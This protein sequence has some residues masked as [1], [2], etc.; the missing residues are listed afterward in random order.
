MKRP[1]VFFIQWQHLHTLRRLFDFTSLISSF[2]FPGSRWFPVAGSGVP[3]PSQRC[4]NAMWLNYY[5]SSFHECYAGLHDVDGKNISLKEVVSFALAAHDPE[6]N[7]SSSI[8]LGKLVSHADSS[9]FRDWYS[10]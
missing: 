7:S 3:A 5:S 4:S 8:F 1:C 6:V 10:V 2:V 9:A